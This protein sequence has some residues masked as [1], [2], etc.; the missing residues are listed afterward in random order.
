[1]GIC[2]DGGGLG[3][4]Q[5]VIINDLFCGIFRQVLIGWI[6]SGLKNE[7]HH[8]LNNVM[9]SFPWNWAKPGTRFPEKIA[10]LQA[11]LSS[12][13]SVS[14]SLSRDGRLHIIVREGECPL[15]LKRQQIGHCSPPKVVQ[16]P[17]C[18]HTPFTRPFNQGEK[19]NLLFHLSAV[20]KLLPCSD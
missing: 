7:H 19:T 17:A 20:R 6:L 2:E 1:M 10:S 13:L 18:R 4:L 5:D 3:T 8:I 11:L 9:P 12:C 14:R 16:H 15:W